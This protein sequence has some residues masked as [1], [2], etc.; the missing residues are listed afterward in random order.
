MGVGVT[1]AMLDLI[2]RAGMRLMVS[3]DGGPETHD[4]LRAKPNGGSTYA[5]VTDTV[6]R[7]VER[8]LRPNI[9]ITVTSLN[10]DGAGEAVTFALERALPFNV[11][12]YRECIPPSSKDRAVRGPLSPSPAQL[13]GTMQ[14][15][16]AI[17]QAYPTYPLPLTGILDRTRLDIPHR[18]ACSAGQDLAVGTAGQVSHARCCW[19]SRGRRWM[20]RSALRGS[21][22]RRTPGRSM[23][24]VWRLPVAHSVQRGCPLLRKS[25]LQRLL[26]GVL[27]LFPE[28]VQLVPSG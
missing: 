23:T 4:R 9:S 17:V 25:V 2:S 6:E 5:A 3:L 18:H 11:N 8:G 20:L 27:A 21:T 19:K 15:I 1:D 16:L 24:I 12:F 10:L 22:A 7:A 28:L 14:G 26:P 13:L